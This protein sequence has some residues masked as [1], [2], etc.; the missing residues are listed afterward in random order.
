MFDAP[1]ANPFEEKIDQMITQL[2]SKSAAKRREAAYFLGEV[3]AADAVPALVEVYKKD[4]N[5]QVRAAAA[6]SLGMYKAVENAIRDG[7]ENEVIRLLRGIEE[8]GE[9]GRRASLGRSVRMIIALLATFIVLLIVYYFSPDIESRLLGSTR[10]RAEVIANVQ[11][12]FILVKNDTRSLQTELLEVISARPLGCIAFF[13]NAPTYA[14]DPVDAR[15]FPDVAALVTQLHTAQASLANTK[16]RY[17]AAC[18]DGA[19]FGASEAQAAFQLLLPA[20]QIIDPLEVSLLQLSAL[21]P[22]AAPATV[23]PAQPTA[24]PNQPTAAPAQ[25]TAAPAGATAQPTI[26]PEVLAGA[27]PK[28]H[29]PALFDIIDTVTDTRGASTLLV[30]YWQDVIDTGTTAG[31]R[32]VAPT[33]PTYDLFIPEVDFQAS[34]DLRDAVELIRNGLSALRNGWTNFQ[35]SCNSR[36]LITVAPT[37]LQD[38]QVAATAFSAAEELLLSV[39]SAP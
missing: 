12:T 4:K 18:N 31:C 37:R 26:A 36:S 8:R 10:P 11:Q 20:L 27:N 6:Y 7:D 32:A 39:Q 30:Q 2:G 3:A 23:A 24:A 9:I 19:P 38:A 1:P 17:D 14:F 16:I 28:S 35:F 33:I 25:P 5:P 34:P 22:T 21:Q 29:L 15:A 13:N